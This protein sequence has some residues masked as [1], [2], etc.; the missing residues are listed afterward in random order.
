MA[1]AQAVW[2]QEA[3][4]PIRLAEKPK[5]VVEASMQKRAPRFVVG[6]G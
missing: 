6:R 5:P 3:Q 4:S 2:Q 1:G